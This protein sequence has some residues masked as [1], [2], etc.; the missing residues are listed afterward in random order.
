[1]HLD[2]HIGVLLLDCTYEPLEVISWQLTMQKLVTGDIEVLEEGEA[3]IRSQ[4]QQWR[5]PSVVRQL[6][7]FQRSKCRSMDKVNR[8]HLFMRDNWTCQ[9]CLK[10]KVPRELTFD[11]VVPK[12]QGGPTTWKNIVTA[13]KRCNN[14]KADKPLDETKMR[15]NRLP[16]KPKWL[17]HQMI[18]KIKSIPE[19]WKLYINDESLRYWIEIIKD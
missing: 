18:L 3:L 19:E 11:H 12:S 15:L 6:K 1:M 5:V 7:K 14:K 16:D 2:D 10:R 4:R 8:V 17:P 13:C 9:Y